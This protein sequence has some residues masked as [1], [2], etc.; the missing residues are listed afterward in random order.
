[1]SC[2]ELYV[3][4]HT[5]SIRVRGAKKEHVQLHWWPRRLWFYLWCWFA[6]KFLGR[7]YEFYLEDLIQIIAPDEE[8]NNL[9][10]H[11]VDGKDGYYRCTAVDLDPEKRQLLLKWLV[12]INQ[13]DQK[14]DCFSF[15]NSLHWSKFPRPIDNSYTVHSPGTGEVS[16]RSARTG[17][18][19]MLYSSQENISKHTVI[20]L[21]PD[22]YLSKCGAGG[23]IYASSTKQ[24]LHFYQ[25]DLI[26]TVCKICKDCQCKRNIDTLLEIKCTEIK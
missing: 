24:I 4:R 26:F 7:P 1:M 17:D 12:T 18:M 8:Y 15:A 25:C 9:I 5:E 21:A 20:Y 13:F 19:M 6:W 10:I 2:I 23:P 22:L 3:S 11:E 14:F 16:D